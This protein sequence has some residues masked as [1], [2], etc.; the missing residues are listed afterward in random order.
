MIS[1]ENWDYNDYEQTD[2]RIMTELLQTD[3]SALPQKWLFVNDQMATCLSRLNG[4][5]M[6]R[7]TLKKPNKIRL[8]N[9]I[10]KIR[11]TLCLEE[12]CVPYSG[13]IRH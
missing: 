3:G 2:G 7:A 11:A 13:S 12:T 8:E 1:G 5:H 4:E 9:S 6:W 10:Q